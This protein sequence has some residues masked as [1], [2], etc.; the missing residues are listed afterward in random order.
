MEALM[1]KTAE[2]RVADGYAEKEAFRKAMVALTEDLRMDELL[3]WL[4]RC[5]RDA[6]PY[7][8]AS[9]LLTEEEDT[10]LF[11]AREWPHASEDREVIT[12]GLNQNPFLARVVLGKKSILVRDTLL[13]GEWK[14]T[15]SLG[16]VSS[17]IAV[18]LIVRR[19]VLG[20]LSIGSRKAA[21]FTTEHFRLAKSLAIPIAVAVD[22]ARLREWALIYAAERETLLVK[23]GLASSSRRVQKPAS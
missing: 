4:L 16:E 20:L 6:V 19:C 15:R 3:D 11:V 18:P 23:A 8:L 12:I 14:E 7:D 5:V 17:W 22:T 10:S 9:L 21:S 1:N 13:E 2:E